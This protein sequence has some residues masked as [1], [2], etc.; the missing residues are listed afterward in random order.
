MASLT[1]NIDDSELRTLIV[2]LSNQPARIQWKGPE[3]L[4]KSGRIVEA[5]MKID[6]RNARRHSPSRIKHLPKGFR[7]DVVHPWR[8]EVGT[9][10]RAGTQGSMAHWFAY[11]TSTSPPIYDHTAGLR[12]ATPRILEIMLEAGADSVLGEDV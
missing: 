2:D 5:E 1:V 6:A 12:R 4:R 9:G 7:W 3:G 11:G 10:P 8:V